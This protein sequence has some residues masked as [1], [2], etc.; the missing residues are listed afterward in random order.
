MDDNS[1]QEYELKK[2]SIGKIIEFLNSEGYANSIVFLTK[3]INAEELGENEQR[4]AG[5][6]FADGD[7]AIIKASVVEMMGVHDGIFQFF[8]NAV[9]EV[10]KNRIKNNPN[11]N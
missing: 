1:E 11:I 7:M 6:T 4:L 2:Q 5:L 8:A 10:R 9:E 3:N